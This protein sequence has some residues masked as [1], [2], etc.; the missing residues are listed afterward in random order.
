MQ[1]VK[2]GVHQRKTDRVSCGNDR[3]EK[4]DVR[5]VLLGPQEGFCEKR[6]KI[7]DICDRQSKNRNEQICLPCASHADKQRS[8]HGKAPHSGAGG[9]ADAAP[10]IDHTVQDLSGRGD[11]QRRAE[12]VRAKLRC[13]APVGHMGGNARLHG[14]DRQSDRKAERQCAPHHPVSEKPAQRHD[15]RFFR[16]GCLR[17]GA[18]LEGKDQD[19]ERRNDGKHPCIEVASGI[20]KGGDRFSRKGGKRCAAYAASGKDH[21][22]NQ[23]RRPVKPCAKNDRHRRSGDQTGRDAL[24]DGR[25]IEHPE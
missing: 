13:K 17:G 1:P 12:H 9:G 24:R 4:A 6:R 15:G 23:S 25:E 7:H 10:V 18:A 8:A 22:E 11:Q 16:G 14:V 19:R 5:S 21:A 3:G 2:A 20:A